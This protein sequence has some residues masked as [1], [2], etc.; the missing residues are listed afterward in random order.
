[1]NA[2]FTPIPVAARWKAW[3]YGRLVAGIA[4][5]N[6]AGSMN[7]CLLRLLCFVRYSSLRRA[8]HSSRGVVRLWSVC[9]SVIS[10]PQQWGRVELLSSHEKKNIWRKVPPSFSFNV[11]HPE[12]FDT[13]INIQRCVSQT[14]KKTLFF[15][16]LY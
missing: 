7:V 6:P 11:C 2:Y 14:Q 13:Y 16:L 8:A 10:K 15:L 9:E 12:V 3:A 4:G 1:M 5:A